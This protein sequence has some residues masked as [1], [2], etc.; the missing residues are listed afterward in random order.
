[1]GAIMLRLCVPCAVKGP[2]GRSLQLHI[3]EGRHTC[4]LACIMPQIEAERR[5]RSRTCMQGQPKQI[6]QPPVSVLCQSFATP[7]PV[8]CEVQLHVHHSHATCVRC[9]STVHVT[10]AAGN[11]PACATHAMCWLQCV[12]AGD[13]AD[14]QFT[15]DMI[16]AVGTRGTLQLQ[17]PRHGP[18]LISYT[19]HNTDN[20]LIEH[21]R[22]RHHSP[23]HHPASAYSMWGIYACSQPCRHAALQ[24]HQPSWLLAAQASIA[25]SWKHER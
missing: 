11:R 17:L 16:L 21:Q 9:S 24:A 3:L 18:L 4:H 2:S 6:P 10:Y 13:A 19:R 14:R 25:R 23:P 20:D 15:K 22:F 1:M 5:C 12:H 7:M 8:L